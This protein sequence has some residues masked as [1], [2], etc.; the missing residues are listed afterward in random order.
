MICPTGKVENIFR[1]GWTG[2]IRLNAFKKFDFTRMRRRCMS[3]VPDG[4]FDTF[5][6]LAA[7]AL[8][9]ANHSGRALVSS[10]PPANSSSFKG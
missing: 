7:N 6:R 10:L 9:N 3:E 8:E 5:R 2:Q 4:T 1:W